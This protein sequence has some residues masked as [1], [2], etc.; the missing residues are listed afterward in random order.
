MSD[1]TKPAEL[2]ELIGK[3][4]LLRFDPTVSSGTLLQIMVLLAGG[5]AAYAQYQT[6]KAIQTREVEQIKAAAV[7]EK[8]AT[9]ESL[10]ELKADVKDVQRTL[11]QVTQTLAVI[12]ERQQPKKP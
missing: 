9:K 7:A 1:D 12:N 6:D 3:R 11:N 5:A 4:K 8:V 2:Q 10:G